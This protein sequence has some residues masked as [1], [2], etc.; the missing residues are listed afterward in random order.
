MEEKKCVGDEKQNRKI[1]RRNKS[2]AYFNH[3]RSNCINFI[4]SVMKVEVKESSKKAERPFPKLMISK[5]NNTTIVLFTSKN[6]GTILQSIDDHNPV[7]YHTQSFAYRFF[8]DFEG[9][10]TLSN[11]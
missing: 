3:R 5:T 8:K 9:E 2:G 11:D 4:D 10:I 1:H 6:E 7:G